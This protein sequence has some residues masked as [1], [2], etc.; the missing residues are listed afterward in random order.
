MLMVMGSAL[1]F[2][3]TIFSVAVYLHGTALVMEFVVYIIFIIIS[4]MHKIDKEEIV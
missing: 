2:L 4:R 1:S 3:L